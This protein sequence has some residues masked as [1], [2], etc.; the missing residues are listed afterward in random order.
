MNNN[1][2]SLDYLEATI[3][4]VVN[5]TIIASA[6]FIN[7]ISGRNAKEVTKQLKNTNGITFMDQMQEVLN[8]LKVMKKQISDLT[9]RFDEIYPEQKVNSILIRNL[10]N[11][12]DDYVAKHRAEQ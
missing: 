3:L 12:F 5:L 4:G 10:T 8:E 9:G 7:K 6:I 1:S 11:R 2:I